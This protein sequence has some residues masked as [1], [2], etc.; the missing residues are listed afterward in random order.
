MY[1]YNL[2]NAFSSFSLAAITFNDNLINL[3]EYEQM[4]IRMF[5]DHFH[6]SFDKLERKFNIYRMKPD[7]DFFVKMFVWRNTDEQRK[8]LFEEHCK[9]EFKRSDS[10]KSTIFDS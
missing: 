6:F 7:K 10:T 3:F 5:I 8:L 9:Y 1:A 4:H 2:V